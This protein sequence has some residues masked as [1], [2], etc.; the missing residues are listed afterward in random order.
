M[1]YPICSGLI[2]SPDIPSGL[3]LRL[4]LSVGSSSYACILKT[5]ACMP[6]CAGLGDSKAANDPPATERLRYQELP[7][8][9]D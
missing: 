3:L 7:A 2:F 9:P 4:R 5:C 6:T 1:T 8:L